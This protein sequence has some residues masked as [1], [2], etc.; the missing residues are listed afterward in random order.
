MRPPRWVQWSLIVVAVL[1]AL[2]LT[3]L[4]FAPRRDDYPASNR[5]LIA[6][7]GAPP[8]AVQFGEGYSERVASSLGPVSGYS[9]RA[10]FVAPEGMTMAEVL[11]FYEV[12]LGSSSSST[13]APV[14]GASADGGAPSPPPS[15]PL[16]GSFRVGSS[17]VAVVE[18]LICEELPPA[19]GAAYFISTD[20][21]R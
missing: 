8:G 7:V 14:A 12:H 1:W 5:A 20:H 15:G 9:S 11:A 16:I 19:G 2:A 4:S 18:G 17:R 13:R 10:C 21:L 3:F 6:S